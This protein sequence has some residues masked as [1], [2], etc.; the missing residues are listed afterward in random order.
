MSNS[1]DEL[2]PI[3]GDQIAEVNLLPQL[4]E[5][6]NLVMNTCEY[7]LKG[8]LIMDNPPFKGFILIGEPGT[9]KTELVK[10]VARKLHRRLGKI[11]FLLLDGASIAAPKWGEAEKKLK[12]VFSRIKDGT[13]NSKTIILFDDIESLMLTRG[14]DLAKEWHYSINSILFHELDRLNPNNTIIFATTNRE[15][16][17]DEA[18]LTRL[19]QIKAPNL[20]VAQL[21]DIVDNILKKGRADESKREYVRGE[22]EKR[23]TEMKSPT[24]RDAMHITVVECI[25][26]RLWST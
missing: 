14:T 23:L 12:G 22:I 15:D 8:N 7:F 17:V 20:P 4:V 10:Q 9:G 3:K 26:K 19:Y 6:E 5:I 21:M 11:D 18:I 16:L 1:K 13:G 24:I 2:T 25:E